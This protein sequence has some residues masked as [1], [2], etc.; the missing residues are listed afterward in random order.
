MAEKK[1]NRTLWIVLAVLLV[2]GGGG[3]VLLCCGGG[4]GLSM[5]GMGMVTEDL[6]RQLA[7]NP[8]LVQEIG[9]LQELSYNLMASGE[10]SDFDVMVYKA[11]GT[12]GTGDIVLLS[13]TVANGEDIQWAVLFPDRG[14]QI[15]LVGTPPAYVQAP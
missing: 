2:C 14:G 10:Q 7:V 9:T 8:L 1:S 3:G 5:F 11:T 13:N 6:E 12:T 4:I 15:T